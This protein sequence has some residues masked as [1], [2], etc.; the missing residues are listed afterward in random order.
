MFSLTKSNSGCR[1][2]PADATDELHHQYETS[3]CLDDA[4]SEHA[5]S[6]LGAGAHGAAHRG[7]M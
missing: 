3:H 6:G 7:H 2:R 4:K 5:R 1:D